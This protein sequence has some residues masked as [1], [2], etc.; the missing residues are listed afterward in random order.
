MVS[1]IDLVF[2]FFIVVCGQHQQTQTAVKSKKIRF[3][4]RRVCGHYFFVYYTI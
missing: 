1:Y 3:R 4:R 2:Y